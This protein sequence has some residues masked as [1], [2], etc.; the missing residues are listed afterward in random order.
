V[1]VCVGVCVCAR[2]IVCMRSF[3]HFL[4]HALSLGD[5]AKQNVNPTPVER[6]LS[7]IGLGLAI[8][9]VLGAIIFNAVYSYS[10]TC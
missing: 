8:A 10:A 3:A 5:T 7:W 9:L 1:C 4:Y 6:V 2:H